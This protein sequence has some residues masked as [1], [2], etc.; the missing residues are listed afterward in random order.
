MIASWDK[1]SPFSISHN[2]GY[3]LLGILGPSLVQDCSNSS[4]LAMELPQPSV[5]NG[6]FFHE[7]SISVQIS[8]QLWIYGSN[9]QYVT[10]TWANVDPDL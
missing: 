2:I 5:L 9:W 1:L 7:N 8:Q 4:L 10:I 6:I 3:W